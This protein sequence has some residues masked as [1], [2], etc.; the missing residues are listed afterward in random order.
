MIVYTFDENG[1]PTGFKYRLNTDEAGAWQVFVYEKN[2]FGDVVAVYTGAGSK[3]VSYTYDAWGNFISNYHNGAT[4]SSPAAKNPFRY[5]GYY[6]DSDLNL[7]YL[8]SRY[9]DSNT[10]RFINADSYVSTGQGLTGYNMYAYCLNNPI[11]R[12]DLDGRCSRFL[13]FLWKIDCKQASC[14]E[15]R[16]YIKPKEIAPIGSYNNGQG[17]VYVVT[18]DQLHIMEDR[19]E[20]ALVI[21]DQRSS[22]DPNMKMLGSY[23]IRN[24]IQQKEIAQL[25]I[26][27]NLANPVNPEWSRSLD[28]LVEEWKLHNFAYMFF[29]NR[30]STADCDFNN[31]AEGMGF[32]DFV[33]MTVW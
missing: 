4:S 3:Q 28:S 10:G 2:I 33:E 11:N 26:D 15:S 12:L 5:R 20:N 18:Q 21:V 1:S 23:R 8:G 9:Y 14:P 17:Y 27:Y 16:N 32:W 30:G 13:G 31:A 6:Y 25:M 29:I 7:Y 19:E 22:S 24:S